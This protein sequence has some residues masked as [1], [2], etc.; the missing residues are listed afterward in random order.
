ME[1]F[2]CGCGGI[3]GYSFSTP[4]FAR[5][6]VFFLLYSLSSQRSLA[7]EKKLMKT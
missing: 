1:A 2:L 6:F 3:F 4:H 5:F 7:M